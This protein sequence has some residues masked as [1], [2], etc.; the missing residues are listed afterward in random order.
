MTRYIR[1]DLNAGFMDLHRLYKAG[2]KV[3]RSNNFSV[4]DQRYHMCILR[5]R[6]DDHKDIKVTVK[7]VLSVTIDGPLKI[8][9]HVA[10]AL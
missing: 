1:F 3:I 8:L 7:I 2:I 10:V 4:F 6:F 9:T 5:K